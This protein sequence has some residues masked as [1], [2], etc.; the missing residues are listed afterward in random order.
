MSSK[1]VRDEIISFL[2]TNSAEKVVDLTA[3]FLSLKDFLAAQTTP[4]SMSDTWLGVQF[5]GAQEIPVDIRG[6]NTRGKYREE[7][8]IYLHVVDVAKLGGH[9]AILTRAETLRNLFRGKR[10]SGTILIQSVSPPNF[11]DGIALSFE[12]GHTACIIQ[13]DYQRDLDL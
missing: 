10:I 3:E 11:G 4:I 12:G 2:Q 7:G 6:T 5:V 1:F 9:N 8:V 13:I